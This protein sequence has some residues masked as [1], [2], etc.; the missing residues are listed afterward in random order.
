MKSCKLNTIGDE[1]SIMNMFFCV[2]F[3]LLFST[4][5]GP[6]NDFFTGGAEILYRCVCV[7]VCV[8]GVWGVGACVLARACVR[9]YVF[10]YAYQRLY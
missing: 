7:C 3:S 9:A 5:Q 6:E 1:E 10:V 8:C 4:G 2:E